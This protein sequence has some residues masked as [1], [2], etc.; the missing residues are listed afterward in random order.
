M[1]QH[2]GQGCSL[3]HFIQVTQTVN[4]GGL[5][6]QIRDHSNTETRGSYQKGEMGLDVL[7]W[8]TAQVV[9]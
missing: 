4:T 2:V 6:R 5:N 7:T 1:Q 3:R 9:V 8:E